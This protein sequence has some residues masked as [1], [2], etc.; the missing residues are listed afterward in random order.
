MSERL[1][2]E[3][4]ANLEASHSAIEN[5]YRPTCESVNYGSG[6][7]GATYHSTAF[8]CDAV[9]AM[10]LLLAE[11]RER[12]ARD[13]RAFID[14]VFDGPPS[15]ESGRFVEVE[16]ERGHS[17]NAGEWIDRGD[18]MFALRISADAINA[19]AKESL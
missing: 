2:T 10:P 7:P 13:A 14:I 6:C 15:H 9:A 19:R 17:V 4:M 1:T 18:G 12:R 5:D 11:I 16:D 3:Q 8:W